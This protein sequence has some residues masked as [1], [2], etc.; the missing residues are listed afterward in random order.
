M[1]S[2]L[3]KFG[4]LVMQRVRDQAIGQFEQSLRPATGVVDEQR[5]DV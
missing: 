1:K 4:I 5:A 2:T 3:E